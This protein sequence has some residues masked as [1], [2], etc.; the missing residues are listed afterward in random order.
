MPVLVRFA[1]TAAVIPSDVSD[2]L[3][4]GPLEPETAQEFAIAKGV[5]CGAPELMLV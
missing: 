1:M 5:D 4:E 3:T 2:P